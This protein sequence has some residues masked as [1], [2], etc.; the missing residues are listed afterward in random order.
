MKKCSSCGAML[1]LTAF[2]RNVTAKDG[3]QYSCRDCRKIYDF[4]RRLNQC[5]TEPRKA[6]KLTREQ[7]Y[8][9]DSLKRY[10]AIKTRRLIA[11]GK[12]AHRAKRK[13]GWFN[14][15]GKAA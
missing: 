10:V 5:R 8:A 2:S 14:T 1:P 15:G 3:L 7:K 12:A 4:Q 6:Y 9:I 11:R 13:V